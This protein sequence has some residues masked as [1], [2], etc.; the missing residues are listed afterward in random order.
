METHCFLGILCSNRVLE[1]VFLQSHLFLTALI[2]YKLTV[3]AQ[4]L[5]KQIIIHGTEKMASLTTLS[6]HTKRMDM[7]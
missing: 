2:L 7:C 3:L 1:E 5:F 6:Y 4:F